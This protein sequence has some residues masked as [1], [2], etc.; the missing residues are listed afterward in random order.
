MGE[1]GL[2][3]VVADLLVSCAA[4]LASAASAAERC[5]HPVAHRPVGGVRPGLGHH[6]GQFVSGHMR[7][8][9]ARVVAMPGEEVAAAQPGRPNLDH[10]AVAGHGWIGKVLDGDRSVEGSEQGASHSRQPYS[11]SEADASARTWTSLFEYFAAAAQTCH[12]IEREIGHWLR[13]VVVRFI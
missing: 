12:V 2:E 4:L 6:S 13:V 7:Q 10:N 1:A 3:V 11:S 8:R 5:G 9:D